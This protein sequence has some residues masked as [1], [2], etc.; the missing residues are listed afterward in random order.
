[1]AR[2]RRLWPDTTDGFD[3]DLLAPM[4]LGAV[5]NPVNSSIIA[6][7]LVPIGIAFGAPPAATAWLVS[8]LYLATAIGQ[9]VVGRLIDVYGPRRLFLAGTALVGIAGGIGTV[10]PNLGV[11]IAARTLLGFGTCAGYPAAMSL[12]SREA[13]RTGRDSPAIVLTLLTLASQTITVI[14]PPLGGV[15]IGLSGWRAT[16]AVNIPL[17]VAAW[18]LGARR[19]PKA[20]LPRQADGTRN[21]MTLDVP[22]MVLFAVTVVASLLFLAHPKPSQWY[23]PFITIAAGS[24]FANR[25]LHAADPFIDLRVLGGNRPLLSTYV[26]TVLA[27]FVSYSFIYG[28]TQWLEQGRGLPASA[29]GLAQ[30]PMFATALL[31]TMATGRRKEL[32]GKLVVGGVGQIAGCLLLL[33]LGHGSTIWLLVVVAMVFGIPQGLT[34]LA[35]QNSVYWQAESDRVGSSAGLLRTFTYVGAIIASAAQGACYGHTAG[36]DGMHRLAL[37]ALVVSVVYLAITVR[38]QSLHDKELSQC[39]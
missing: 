5:L 24:G 38:D 23:L 39:G 36:T 19:L 30:L 31:V 29:A 16:L 15:L 18:V 4:M 8:A 37:A 7:S 11:L 20:P 26:R 10:A 13:V 12:I 35:L 9:P 2:M 22:G 1:M 32:W 14:G 25:E 28:Y 3:R 34:G 27:Y 33:T 21:R 17:A 6:V